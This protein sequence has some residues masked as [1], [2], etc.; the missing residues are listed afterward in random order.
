VVLLWRCFPHV[1]F[2]HWPSSRS[3]FFGTLAAAEETEALFY[4]EEYQESVK[5]IYQRDVPE[6]PPNPWRVFYFRSLD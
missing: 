4:C 6:Y 5:S 3:V 2:K 1:A